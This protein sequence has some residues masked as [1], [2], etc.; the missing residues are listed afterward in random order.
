MRTMGEESILHAPMANSVN[1]ADLGRR[2]RAF[3][4][5]RRMTL[6]DVVSRTDFTVS[7]L[8]KLENGQLTPSL[9]GLVR[10]AEVLQCGVE[11]LVEGLSMPPQFVVVKNGAGRKETARGGKPGVIVES[12]ADEWRNRVMD[13]LILHISGNGNR[14]RPDNHDGERFLLVLE[15]DVKIAYGDEQIPLS[16]GDSIYIY[17]AIPHTIVPAG[18]GSAKVLSVSCERAHAPHDR[19]ARRSGK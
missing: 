2:V 16:A 10:L 11:G 13:P 6:E 8:S 15:G 19:P 7:W 4:L 18:R 5:A 3:R 1:L 9:E 17:A 14:D 12:L